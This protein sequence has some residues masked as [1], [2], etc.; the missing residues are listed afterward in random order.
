MIKLKIKYP[1]KFISYNCK[2][3]TS[4]SLKGKFEILNNHEN[5]I[6][7]INDENIYIKTIDKNIV[8]FVKKTSILHYIRSNNTCEIIIY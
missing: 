8:L 6:L 7:I 1:D 3:I 2:S 5:I 4:V